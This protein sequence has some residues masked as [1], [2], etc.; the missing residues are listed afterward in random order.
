MGFV[1]KLIAKI[2]DKQSLR[3]YVC[4]SCGVEIFDYPYHRFCEA[5]EAVMR[6][7]VGL[8]CDKC[9]RHTL[10][11]GVCLTCKRDMPTFTQ[12]FSPFVYRAETASL[13]NRIKNG[14]PR[15]AYYFGE[16]MAEYL[17]TERERQKS[18]LDRGR[19]ALNE[20][21]NDKAE[22]KYTEFLIVPVPITE[23]K[24]KQRGYNQ[25]EELAVVIE[26][27]LQAAGLSATLD[28]EVLQKNRE[29]KQQKQS[30]YQARR[31][32]VEGAY[33][34]HK[35]KACREKTILLIDDIMT[36]GA[37][38]SECASRLFGAGAKE[39]FL[40]VAASLPEQK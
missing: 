29:T 10:A 37:T 17:L 24:R 15:L 18:S 6:K 32:N 40:L 28:V 22:E 1:Q 5:C 13:I 23:E 33:H 20:E 14:T 26:Q 30:S 19:Y 34:V 25:A 3:G 38:G 11:Q 2:R 39:V 36:T 4:D 12:G 35:R 16:Q 9:G 21:N 7:N 31:E 27:E 8:R